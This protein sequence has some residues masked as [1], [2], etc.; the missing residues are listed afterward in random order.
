MCYHVFFFFLNKK[1]RPRFIY[2]FLFYLQD[3]I[4]LVCPSLP[5]ISVSSSGKIRGASVKCEVRQGLPGARAHCVPLAG[6]LIHILSVT[7]KVVVLDG[8]PNGQWAKG[9]GYVCWQTMLS[10]LVGEPWPLWALFPCMG[11]GGTGISGVFEKMVVIF[12]LFVL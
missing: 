4:F 3:Y 8:R 2:S 7:R 12:L 1:L 11:L 5:L 10:N 9:K 6:G